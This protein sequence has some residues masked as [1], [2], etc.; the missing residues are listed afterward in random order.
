MDVTTVRCLIVYR[1]PPLAAAAMRVLDDGDLHA[2]RPQPL[3]HPG[4]DRGIGHENV[5]G[6]ATRIPSAM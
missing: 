4:R 6:V 3:E 1:T 5:D 2:G